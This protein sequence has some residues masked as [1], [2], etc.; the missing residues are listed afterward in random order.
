MALKSPPIVVGIR[1]T[2]SD[3]NTGNEVRTTPV[4]FAAFSS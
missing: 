1:Q 3:N 2:I 4:W